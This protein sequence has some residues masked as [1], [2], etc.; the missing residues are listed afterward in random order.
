MPSNLTM[1][2]PYRV[3]TITANGHIG[4]SIQQSVFF[5]H[6]H[7][8]AFESDTPGFIWI[9][10]GTQ[11]TRGTFPKKRRKTERKIFDNQITV[12]YKIKEGYMPNIKL[13]RNGNIQMTGIR[14]VED[15][16]KIIEIMTEEVRR[17]A[18]AGSLSQI[19]EEMKPIVEDAEVLKG[20]DFTIRMINSDFAV[21]YKIRRKELHRLLMED[22][23]N[24]CS[25]QPETYPGVKLQYFWNQ[26]SNK[27]DGCCHCPTMCFGKEDGKS[28]CKKVTVSIFQSGKVLITGATSFKQVDDAYQYITKILEEQKERIELNLTALTGIVF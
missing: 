27:H 15:G 24:K 3:S 11:H 1:A 8:V 6:V 12:I 14:T 4:S 26:Q 7:L 17:I 20:R 9:E 23:G 18:K 5:E 2:T 22:Y 25:Y 21:P 28:Q 19:G 13:F 10:W 16:I